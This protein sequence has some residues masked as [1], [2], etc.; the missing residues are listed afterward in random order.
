[1]T[2]TSKMIILHGKALITEPNKQQ[3]EEKGLCYSVQF[4]ILTHIS[5]CVF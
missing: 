4:W 3:R 5:F 1:M 2:I